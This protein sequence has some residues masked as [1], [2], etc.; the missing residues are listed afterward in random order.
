MQLSLKEFVSKG[1][2]AILPGMADNDGLRP[3]SLYFFSSQF[4]CPLREEQKEEV[5][6]L[7]VAHFQCEYLDSSIIQKWAAVD[8]IEPYRGLSAEMG[9][10]PH[11]ITHFE[12]DFHCKEELHRLR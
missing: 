2:F 3:G 6:C 7:L 12:G 8:Q 4:P 11:S 5:M 10:I 9:E 1:W